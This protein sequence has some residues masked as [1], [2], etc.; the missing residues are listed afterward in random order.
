MR[1]GRGFTSYFVPAAAG[2]GVFGMLGSFDLA[3]GQAFLRA[4]RLG[5]HD[6]LAASIFGVAQHH[7]S[8][9]HRLAQRF[10]RLWPALATPPGFGRR[11]H[12]KWCLRVPGLVFS[13][14]FPRRDSRPAV[15]ELLGAAKRSLH[16]NAGETQPAR[17]AIRFPT[18][19]GTA[20]QDPGVLLTSFALQ[21]SSSQL[22]NS[23]TAWHR[24]Q[25]HRSSTSL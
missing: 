13:K 12:A 11:G 6:R 3:I 23:F 16:R 10:E 18:P 15:A 20:I 22:R 5:L 19:R 24:K 25:L 2:P 7:R 4:R 14:S 17:R 9:I 1:R 21:R 8:Q